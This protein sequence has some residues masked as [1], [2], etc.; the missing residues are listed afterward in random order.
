MDDGTVTKPQSSQN[1]L[2]RKR[3]RNPRFYPDLVGS[4]G[5][6]EFKTGK[7]DKILIVAMA[8][9][10]WRRSMFDCLVLA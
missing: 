9:D 10:L 8:K 6:P 1:V 5:D 2:I 4:W 7:I 3:L